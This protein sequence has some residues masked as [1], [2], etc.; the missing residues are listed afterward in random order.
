MLVIGSKIRELG[1][2]YYCKNAGR[3]LVQGVLL[4]WKHL[5]F[6]VTYL[7]SVGNEGIEKRMETTIMGHTGTTI[8]ILSP[9][10]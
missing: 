5:Y 2:R 9:K 8:R 1:L 3:F 10:P 6:I 4:Q 7:W